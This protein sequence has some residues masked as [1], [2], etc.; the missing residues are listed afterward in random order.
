M[1][2]NRVSIGVQSLNDNVLKAIGRRHNS[3]AALKTLEKAG[4][5]F[6]NVSADLM[7][8]LPLMQNAECRMQN[9]GNDLTRRRNEANEANN[10]AT[11][12]DSRC[13]IHKNKA[14]SSLLKVVRA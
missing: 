13:T 9:C 7:I 5:V 6:N 4:K 8:G 1:G 14:H 12:H 10:T 3:L 2:I 11:M